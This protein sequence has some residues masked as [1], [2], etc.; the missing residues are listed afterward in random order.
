MSLGAHTDTG[1][2]HSGQKV[3]YTDVYVDVSYYKILKITA[4]TFGHSY[5]N[6]DPT[7]GAAITVFYDNPDVQDITYTNVTKQNTYVGENS[8][9]WN[10]SN[11]S[12]TNISNWDTAYGWG[13]HSTRGYLTSFDITTQTDGRYLRSDSNDTASGNLYFSSSYNRFNTGNSNNT[14]SADNVGLHLH[15]AGYTDGRYT[16]RLRK[17]DHGGG[18]P[19]Y[20]DNSAGTA[21]VFTAV[22]RFGTYSGNGYG[23]EVFGAARINGDLASSGQINASGGN[24]S[25]W[26]TAYGW[27]NHAAYGYLTQHPTIAAASSSDNSGRTY[28]QD[29]LL[30]SNGHITGITTATETVVNTDTDTITRVGISGSETTGT[31]T[32]TTSGSSSISQVGSTV[33]ISST[34]NYLNAVSWNSSTGVITFGREGL[35]SLTLDIDGKYAESGHS[36]NVY[37]LNNFISGQDPN[38][39]SQ[40]R[41]WSS[42][43]GGTAGN[44]P[45]AYNGVVNLGMDASHG[46]QFS[47]HY[48]ATDD[49]LWFRHKSDNPSA[50]N[51]AGWQGWQR[52]ASQSWVSS[53]GY[54]TAH[55]SVSAAS[56][57]NNSGRT[58]IQDILLDS[59]GHIT[60]ITTATE[61]VT[62]TDTNYYTTGATFNTSNGIITGTRNDG[63]TWTVDID[64][65]YAESSHTH[66]DRYY[67][68][69]ESDARFVNSSGDTMSGNLNMGSNAI[70]IG[71][72]TIQQNANGDLEFSY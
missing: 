47:Y 19:L 34:N 50:P 40:T 15:Q 22:A 71:S 62:N 32:L 4:D 1:W 18:V 44:Y 49:A 58:Y 39:Y 25:Q 59:Y 10:S 63:G 52:L 66:D 46:L 72:Y 67:T 23:F 16:T 56:S 28:I 29:I 43:N 5:Q 3:Y 30:D 37:D 53:R 45:S 26:N 54:L 64:G 12:S 2:L 21:N 69:S 38:T 13:D 33:T 55:P 48:G 60:G 42:L 57:S 51:G 36:H 11:F 6:T 65:K 68:E 8:V 27:G 14:S 61:T 24:S 20:I 41:F 7:A 9:I 31:V 70:V 17:Y 35:N